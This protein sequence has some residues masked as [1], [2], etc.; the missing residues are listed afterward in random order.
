MM[1]LMFKNDIISLKTQRKDTNMKIIIPENVNTIINTLEKNGFEAYIVGGCV[2]DSILKRQPNDWDICTS[3]SPSDTLKIFSPK[4]HVIETGLRHGT[5]T[6]VIGGEQYEVTTFRID[7]EYSDNRRPDS[8]KFTK[9]I[10]DDLARRDFTINAMAYNDKTGIIDL[11]D[12]FN[13]YKRRLIRSVGDAKDRFEEDSLR[14]L[15]AV[16]FASQLDFDIEQNTS[17]AV[18]EQKNLLKNISAERINVE[19]CKT[20]TGVSGVKMLDLYKEVFAVFIPEIKAM[21]NFEQ[22][23]FHHIYD[24]WGH[25]VKALESAPNDL[26]IKLSV[27]FHDIGKP[28]VFFKDENGVGHFYG[29]AKVSADMTDKILK[30]LRFDNNIRKSVHELIYYHDSEILNGNKYIKRWLAKIGEVQLRRLLEVKRSDTNG[31]APQFIP[32]RI[33]FFNET[34]K[35]I[36]EIIS[37]KQCFTQKELAVNGKDLISMGVEPGKT[38][39]VI[40]NRLLKAVIDDKIENE[41]DILMKNAREIFMN[42]SD[43]Q[44]NLK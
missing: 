32:E 7:G 4:Y 12:G 39:G 28:S 38:V 26:I 8:V 33:A 20:L 10:N 16:R 43:S 25:T 24:V 17:K 35:K 30:R 44:K 21:F 5:V 18:F 37:Q 9:N 3:A 41:H 31:L 23:N 34:E 42:F 13:D 11:Y 2:R 14:I 36:D 22:H 27:L 19:L 6:I 15:R 1:N 40:L 29:H